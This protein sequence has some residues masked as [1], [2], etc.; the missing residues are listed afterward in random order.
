MAK[1]TSGGSG[2]GDHSG[3]HSGGFSSLSSMP[4]TQSLLYNYN[5]LQSIQSLFSSNSTANNA[6]TNKLQ[7]IPSLPLD[8]RA[9]KWRAQSDQMSEYRAKMA[10]QEADIAEL[11]RVLKTKL[12]EVSE[13]QIRRDLAEKKLASA[14]KETMGKQAEIERLLGEMREKEAEWERTAN[15]YNAEMKEIY[16]ENQLMKEKFKDIKQSALITKIMSSPSVQQSGGGSQGGALGQGGSSSLGNTSLLNMSF[17]TAMSSPGG[18]SSPTT[19]HSGSPSMTA[20]SV[21]GSSVLGLGGVGFSGDVG[22]L[23][24]TINALRQA[25]KRMAK[26]NYDLRVLLSALPASSSSTSFSSTP[27]STIDPLKTTMEKSSQLKPFWYVESLRKSRQRQAQYSSAEGHNG[28]F[29]KFGHDLKELKLAEMRNKLLD[30]KYTVMSDRCSRIPLLPE[31][32]T[33]VKKPGWTR[34]LGDLLKKGA[35]EEALVRAEHGRRYR[36]LKGQVEDFLKGFEEG[37][38][39]E[40]DYATFLAPHISKVSKRKL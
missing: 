25:L 13:M 30:F 8:E 10:T 32:E 37:Y 4:T 1:S 5:S 19:V 18:Y 38:A 24:E 17:Q 29:P 3:E 12:D 31:T 11:K 20:T 36:E 2:A 28:G 40:A 15:R 9:A 34:C 21:G 14:V 16:S 39:C 23:H 6:N 7:L 27:L 22:E 26:R 35:Q 33:I